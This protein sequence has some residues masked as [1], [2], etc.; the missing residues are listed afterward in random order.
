MRADRLGLMP[1]ASDRDLWIRVRDGSPDALATFFER[2]AR[3]VYNYCFRRTADWGLAED[4]TSAVFLEAWRRRA[5]V[6]EPDDSMLPWLLG[7]ATNLLRN[8]RRALRRYQAAQSRVPVWHTDPDFADEVARRLDAER[9]MRSVL[10]VA[11]RLPRQDQEVLALCGWMQLSYQDAA[12]ALRIPVG[13][14]RS[15]LSRARARL[16]E[17]SGSAGQEEGEILD[18]VVG[19]RQARG[20]TDHED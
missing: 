2:H 3:A 10:E 12:L 16:R 1:E 5:D 17:L 14:V 19:I 11:G 13:T 6:A 9:R 4:L 8:A 7:V 15:R 20:G 18:P